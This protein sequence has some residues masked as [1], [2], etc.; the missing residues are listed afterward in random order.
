MAGLLVLLSSIALCSSTMEL[1]KALGG[2]PREDPLEVKVLQHGDDLVD[3]W[4]AGLGVT[5]GLRTNLVDKWL[6]IPYAVPPIG[7]NRWKKPRILRNWAAPTNSITQ[8]T[9]ERSGR[10]DYSATGGDPMN[11][12]SFLDSC[13]A[14]IAGGSWIRAEPESEDCLALNVFV[15]RRHV[16]KVR[17]GTAKP[18]PVIIYIHGGGFILGSGSNPSTAPPPDTLVA[19]AG[20]QSVNSNGSNSSSQRVR[21]VMYTMWYLLFRLQT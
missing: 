3:L 21:D 15:P 8:A 2:M 14:V 19:S 9:L 10:M 18:L 17:D 5:R 12:T 16:E 7:E 20:K 13:H 6:G 11:A 1:R 4:V